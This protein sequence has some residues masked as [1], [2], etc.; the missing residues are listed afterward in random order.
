MDQ[1]GTDPE[2]REAIWGNPGSRSSSVNYQY[3]DDQLQL[4]WVTNVPNNNQEALN[5]FHRLVTWGFRP[6]FVQVKLPG[7]DQYE[8]LPYQYNPDTGKWIRYERGK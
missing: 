4:I 2:V 1:P 5:Y 3:L 8:I 6:R 7:K